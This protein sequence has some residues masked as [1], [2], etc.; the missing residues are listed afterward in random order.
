MLDRDIQ[1]FWYLEQDRLYECH[2]YLDLHCMR[3]HLQDY[4]CPLNLFVNNTCMLSNNKLK[5]G[6]LTH[7][8]VAIIQ[9]QLTLLSS[10]PLSGLTR[11]AKC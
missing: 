10:L 1:F 4:I 2:H 5:K 7:K 3:S 11:K 8:L 6:K 9:M